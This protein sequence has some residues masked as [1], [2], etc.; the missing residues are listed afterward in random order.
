MAGFDPAKEAINV[1]K[2]GSSLTR[3]VDLDIKKTFEV[4]SRKYGE[5]RYR[6]FGYI[7]GIAY[8]F[9]FTDR[10]GAVRPISLR[11]AHMNEMRRHGT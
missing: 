6:A 10:D 7:D 11:R 5:I 4:D 3:W 1:A 9:V 2:H 8:C